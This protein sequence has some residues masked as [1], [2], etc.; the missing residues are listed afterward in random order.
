MCYLIG[1]YVSLLSFH[2]NAPSNHC[3]A[4]NHHTLKLLL[5]YKS[6]RYKGHILREDG[7]NGEIVKE[8]LGKEITC[9]GGWDAKVC[10]I[11]NS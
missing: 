7:E 10:R 11:I 9:Q 2:E 4:I 6:N 3:P 1:D 5:F 8:V